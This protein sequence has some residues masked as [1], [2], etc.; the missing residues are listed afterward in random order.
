MRSLPKLPKGWTY[1]HYGS[2]PEYAQYY[3]VA[4]GPSGPDGIFKRIEVHA[5][6]YI[7]LIEELEKELE[8]LN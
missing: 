3:V 1:L 7:Y 2:P 6:T 8:G 5:L 4:V